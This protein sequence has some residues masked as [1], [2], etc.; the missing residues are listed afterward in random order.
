M[1]SLAPHT[2]WGVMQPQPD[3]W[4]PTGQHNQD[5]NITSSVHHVLLAKDPAIPRDALVNEAE[6]TLLKFQESETR[7]T[8]CCQ[9]VML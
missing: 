8:S 7:L 3:G 2:H 6:I 1:G 4:T 9:Q 5:G